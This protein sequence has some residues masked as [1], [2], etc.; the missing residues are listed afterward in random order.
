MNIDWHEFW[1]V[2]TQ[3]YVPLRQFML[4]IRSGVLLARTQKIE[5]FG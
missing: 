1:T 5:I 3:I 4:R 2:I